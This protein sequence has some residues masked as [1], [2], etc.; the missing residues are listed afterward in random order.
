VAKADAKAIQ[1]AYVDLIETYIQLVPQSTERLRFLALCWARKAGR[2]PFPQRPRGMWRWGLR[3]AVLE[4]LWLASRRAARALGTADTL[5]LW[6]CRLLHWRPRRRVAPA[7]FGR[8]AWRRVG[9][10]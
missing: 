9:G 4:S 3:A 5:L 2:G 1:R 10:G 7:D 6:A 8:P